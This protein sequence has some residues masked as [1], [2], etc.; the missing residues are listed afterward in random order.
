MIATLAAM[1]PH[2]FASAQSINIDFGTGRG[3]PNYF[4]PAAGEFGF[5]NTITLEV[6]TSFQLDNTNHASTPARIR[7]V[8]FYGATFPTGATDKVPDGPWAGLIG[9]YVF[10]VSNEGSLQFSGLAS[11][12]YDVIVYTV[13]R[14]DFPYTRSV[15][16]EGETRYATSVFGGSLVEGET[17]TRHRVRIDD[18]TLDLSLYGGAD[19][20]SNGVQLVLVPSPSA[21]VLLMIGGVS[22]ARRRRG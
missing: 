20:S 2:S 14:Q 9:D 18:G 13:G 8:G 11:G 16:I 17:H 1:L 4:Y 12:V 15:T 10:G 22:A 19:V 7:F 3:T 6:G 21:A 5:W